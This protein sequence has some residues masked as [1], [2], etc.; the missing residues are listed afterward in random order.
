MINVRDEVRGKF[1]NVLDWSYKNNTKSY[2]QGSVLYN[3]NL[4][5][6]VDSR[7]LDLAYLE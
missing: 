2:L 7:Y 1:F 4:Q 5:N 3:G 6:T